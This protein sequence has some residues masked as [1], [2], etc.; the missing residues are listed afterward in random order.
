M[1]PVI[2][3]AL[4][5]FLLAGSDSELLECQAI[6]TDTARL[7]CYDKAMGRATSEMAPAPEPVATQDTVVEDSGIE[8]ETVSDIDLEEL[9]GISANETEK[10][11]EEAIG[12][13]S[14]D[15]IEARVTKVHR[16]PAGK[17]V[18]ALENQQRWIQLD[19]KRLNLHPGEKVRVRRGAMNSF[20]MAKSVGG[21]SIRVKRID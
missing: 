18:I 9:F 8:Q 19:S 7:A 4:V 12:I 10:L 11:V 13:E 5:V 16:N 1:S 2:T 14:I 21:L 3:S 17:M 6:Q 15:A 20:L